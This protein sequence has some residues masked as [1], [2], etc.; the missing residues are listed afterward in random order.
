MKTCG[1][2][3]SVH[4]IVMEMKALDLIFW[5]EPPLVL[6]LESPKNPLTL[7]PWA[8]DK[9]TPLYYKYQMTSHING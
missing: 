6:H 8:E 2:E 4:H 5:G 3:K 9:S 7:L 1:H